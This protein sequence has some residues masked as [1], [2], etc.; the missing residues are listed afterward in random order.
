[1]QIDLVKKEE[2]SKA[3]IQV[4][5]DS[6]KQ[7]LND[8]EINPLLLQQHFK[9][10]E[11]LQEAIKDDLRKH[12]ISEAERYP[13]KEFMSYG[14][15]FTKGEYGTKYDYEGTGDPVW[16]RLKFEA[17]AAKNELSAREAF[18]KGL[19]KAEDVVDTETGEVVKV[20]PPVKTSITAIAC[21]IK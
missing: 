15:V 4:Y 20:T 5:A 7:K 14:A 2:I 18:L 21:S 16:M 9:A 12:S 10:I 3:E 17:D 11:K 6:L 19:K 13:G 8:G 1:M